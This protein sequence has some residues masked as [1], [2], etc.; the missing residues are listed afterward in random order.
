MIVMVQLFMLTHLVDAAL[1]NSR[2]MRKKSFV[3]DASDGVGIVYDEWRVPMVHCRNRSSLLASKGDREHEKDKNSKNSYNNSQRKTRDPIPSSPLEGISS[4]FE[5]GDSLKKSDES[6]DQSNEDTNS[7][8]TGDMIDKR[9]EQLNR[10]L[11]Y[12]SFLGSER[13]DNDLTGSSAFADKSPLE[14]VL[15]VSELFYRSTPESVEGDDDEEDDPNTS[16]KDPDDEELPFS[17]EQTNS[18]ETYCNKVQ[19]RRNQVEGTAEDDN[20]DDDDALNEKSIEEPRKP[21][22]RRNRMRKKKRRTALNK[23]KASDKLGDVAAL[24]IQEHETPNQNKNKPKNKRKSKKMV[25]RGMEM[26]VGGEPINADP[27]LRVIDLHFDHN[28]NDWA[29]IITL[30]SRDFGPLMHTQ[31]VSKVSPISRGLFCEHF[32]ETS[33]KWNVCPENLSEIVNWYLKVT[34]GTEHPSKPPITSY[35]ELLELM[36]NRLDEV[37]SAKKDEEDT[38]DIK[39]HENEALSLDSSTK[40]IQKSPSPSPGLGFGQTKNMKQTKKR[41][42]SVQSNNQTGQDRSET[43]F[44]VQS[45][46]KFTIGIS[47]AELERG[48]GGGFRVLRRIIAR[49]IESIIDLESQGLSVRVN[50]LT[51]TE[52]EDGTEIDACF[53]INIEGNRMQSRRRDKLINRMNQELVQAVD[54]GDMVIALAKSTREETAW[55]PHFKAKVISEMIMTYSDAFDEI[56]DEIN[57]DIEDENSQSTDNY[58]VKSAMDKSQESNV[59]DSKPFDKAESRN[60]SVDDIFLGNG[61]GG[62]FPNYAESKKSESP[63]CGNLGPLLL[64]AVVEKAKQNQPRVI[65]IGDVH[66][67]IDEL[68]ALLRRC[69]YSPGDVVIF[70]GDLVSKGP[71]SLSVVQMAREIGAIG[72]RG[73]HDFEVIRWHQ[74]IKSGADPPGIASEHFNIASSLESADLKWL[75]SLPWYLSSKELNSLFV[76]AGFVSGIRLAKQNPRLMMNMRSILPDGTVTSKFFHN[77]PWARLWDGPQTV[78]FGHDADR[79]LQQ[80]EHA[81]GMDTGCVYG[82][83]L[84]ACILPEKR[85]VS[86]SAKREYFQYRRKHYD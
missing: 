63:F 47:A 5:A 53:D 38:N 14:G 25:R 55:S 1:M 22:K 15:P 64:D 12:P 18:L 59:D 35:C 32:V 7:S 67:C 66:G 3:K 51:V 85:L 37:V 26:L 21:A 43:S 73:N 40:E 48:E 58:V 36:T 45:E 31:S 83:R 27:P 71:D 11:E 81:I 41:Q 23:T 33:L 74:A 62:V 10:L 6:H 56:S 4:L 28:A 60:F 2:C 24:F 50:R 29:Q 70:L 52:E 68:Q 8:D 82:G 19:V 86:V 16:D 17:A 54:S 34:D 42:S 65:A 75:Y 80:Y 77:W 61:N 79:G 69:N 39:T 72:V 78:F 84:S 9:Q 20:D 30:N 76:H 49:G 13:L 57:D 44:S 46:I